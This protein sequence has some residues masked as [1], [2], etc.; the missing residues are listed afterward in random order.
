MIEEHFGNKYEKKNHNVFD[1]IYFINLDMEIRE[2]YTNKIGFRKGSEGIPL[3][4]IIN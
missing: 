2:M 3:L 1:F 4:G